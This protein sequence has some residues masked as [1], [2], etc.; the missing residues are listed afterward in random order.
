MVFNDRVDAATVSFTTIT[1]VEKVT[2]SSPP[3]QFLVDGSRVVFRP[4]LLETPTGLQFGFID[5][6]E[7][8]VRLAASPQTAVVHSRIGRPNT[9]PLTCVVRTSG[10]ADLVPGDPS[11]S[12]T[13]N[14]ANP[15]P[16]RDFDIV[17]TFNDLMQK[18]QLVDPQ[19]GESPTISV[20]LVEQS[21]GGTLEI[22]VMGTFTAELDQDS[23]TTKVIFD[24]VSDYPGNKNGSRTLRLD[25]S[26]Q[27]SDLAGNTLSNSGSFTIPLPASSTTPGSFEETF[28]DQTQED[29]MG[30]VATLWGNPAGYLDS[31]LD[32]V[33]GLHKGG[34][35][36]VLGAFSPASDFEFDTDT[37]T[38]LVSE[39]E[40]LIG[41]D[42]IIDAT[43]GNHV[44]M[45]ESIH[46]P[47]GITVSAI[48][49]NP[50]RLVSRGEIIV[51]GTL[52][53]DGEAAPSNFAKFFPI[54][55]ESISNESTQGV[56]PLES[57]G[58]DPAL[59]KLTGGAGGKGGWAWYN[60]VVYYDENNPDPYQNQG[61]APD[62]GRY[63][64]FLQSDAAHGFNGE[65]IG[66]Y[67]P[68]GRPLLTPGDIPTDLQNGCGMGSWAWPLVSNGYFRDPVNFADP[69]TIRTHLNP[70]TSLYENIVTHRAR[71]GGGGGFWTEGQQGNFYDEDSTDPLGNR[72]GDNPDLNEPVIDAPNDIWEYN[73]DYAWDSVNGGSVMDASGGMV[74]LLTLYAGIETLNPYAVGGSLLLGGAGGGGAGSGEHGSYDD[75][76]WQT[77]G[78]VDTY[79]NSDGAGGG[80]GGGAM[81]LQGGNRLTVSG[82]L[83]AEGGDGGD[84][85]FM[86]NIPYQPE[87]LISIARPGDAGGGAGSGGSI[88]LQICG[89]LQVDADAISVAG[90]EGGL[91]SVGN[92]G[93]DGGSGLIRFETATGSQSLAE[94]QA[95]VMPDEAVDL[96]PIG[97]NGVPN[98]APLA[99]SWMNGDGDILATDGTLFRGNSSGVRSLW[100]GPDDEIFVITVSDYE[101]V[102]EYDRMD[103]NGPQELRFGPNSADGTTDPGVTEIWVAMQVAFSSSS[104]GGPFE[105]DPGTES[106]WV[107]PGFNGVTDGL[108]EIQSNF[109]RIFRYQIVFDHDL[110]QTRIGTNAGAYFRVREVSMD[111]DGD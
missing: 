12:F 73:V 63:V 18:F 87:N 2:G 84:S 98:V 108:L 7:Y 42:I 109:M 24:A 105:P 50:L 16:T 60:V 43:N 80:A 97:Q 19:T 110:I 89:D 88:L 21:P 26:P 96:T 1:I 27:I 35:H 28:D 79:R 82:E 20:K 69:V 86:V 101:F 38:F 76:L 30:S 4:A 6:A 11:V 70:T 78:L 95:M 90:G 55:R 72:L 99:T 106:T 83:R 40:N 91:G 33:T 57:K 5:G 94:L 13:P 14:A 52:A 17:I 62:P 23:L 102:C 107:I 67:V 32:P 61:F 77:P 22:D 46:I 104:G 39:Y 45:F 81:Q 85:E 9:T 8:E 34:G 25:F 68:V 56:T 75:P 53:A 59:G 31:G 58:G 92:H 3:G 29:G 51:E 103:G 37:T 54:L 74:D 36:G 100:Y 47:P 49:T 71:G 44:F 64:D 65:G 48:G 41:E 66:G 93:G 15:P 111:W 10:I